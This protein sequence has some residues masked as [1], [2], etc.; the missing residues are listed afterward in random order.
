MKNLTYPLITENLSVHFGGLQAV[1]DVSFTAEEGM[2]HAIIGPNGAGKTTFFNLISGLLQPSAG[3][4]RLF[5]HD[6]TKLSPQQRATLGVGRTF[7]VVNI[8]SSLTVLENLLLAAQSQKN[9]K[10]VFYRNG[11]SYRS[12]SIKAREMMDEWDFSEKSDTLAQTLSHGDQRQLD[13]MLALIGEPRL[14]LLD[15]PTA[16][17]SRAETTTLTEIIRTLSLKT[18][19]LMIEHDIEVAFALARRITVLYEGRIFADGSP[20]EIRVDPRVKEI[21]LGEEEV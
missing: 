8:F 9:M 6:V 7:Q 4:I 21:Y 19:I 18:T 15:E 11:T 13:L 10:F 2:I 20:D 12:L 1:A 3:R 5:G 17:L 14:L 16:G